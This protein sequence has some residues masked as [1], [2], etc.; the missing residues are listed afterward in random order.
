MH[1]RCT[2]KDAVVRSAGCRRLVAPRTRA[3][4]FDSRDKQTTIFTTAASLQ[5][6]SGGRKL[7]KALE[8]LVIFQNHGRAHDIAS[9]ERYVT[10]SCQRTAC[11][12]EVIW[13]LAYDRVNDLQSTAGRGDALMYISS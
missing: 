4:I 3:A 12:T 7:R 11:G 8:S 10:Q 5:Q 9:P 6:T 13:K 1:T 2:S